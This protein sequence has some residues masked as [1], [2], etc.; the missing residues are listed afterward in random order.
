MNLYSL[1]VAQSW[2]ALLFVLFDARSTK[3]KI[4]ESVICIHLVVTIS[5]KDEER[6]D[7]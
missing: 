3:Y 7:F 5:G 6:Y 1:C 2:N 4:M